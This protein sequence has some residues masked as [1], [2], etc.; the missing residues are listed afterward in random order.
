MARICVL[1][2]DG[3]GVEV[4]REGVRALRAA[5]KR[6]GLRLEIEEALFGGVATDATGDPLPETTLALC[7]AAD[8]VFLGAAGGPKWETVPKAKRPESG[9]LRLRWEL[10]TYANLRPSKAYAPL[11]SVSP[12]KRE[13][14]EGA[15][16]LFVREECGGLYYG[17]PKGITGT[18]AVDTLVYDEHEIRRVCRVAFQLAEKRR[19]VL[20]SVDKANVLAT[21]ELWRT[22]VKSMAKEHP[23][24]KLNHLLVDTAS[25]RLVMNPRDFDVIVTENSFGDILTDEAAVLS[26]SIGMLPSACIGD[27]HQIYEPVHGSAPDIAGKDI[28][29]PLGAILSAALLLRYSVKHEEAAQALERAVDAVLERGLRTKDIEEDG[30]TVIGTE[31]MGTR[32]AERILAGE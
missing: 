30:T 5:E 25:M 13:V 31:E 29:N 23:N 16:V 8:A 28:A 20:T 9:L 22:T 26:G 32:V 17:Q 27:E 21:S 3:C 10:Q 18:R 19:S 15:D 1:P 7:R 24:V 11:L 2:G 12:L 14:V 4:I 6:F